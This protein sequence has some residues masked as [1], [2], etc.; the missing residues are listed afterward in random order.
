MYHSIPWI[1]SSDAHQL[2]DIGRKTTGLYMNHA[3]FEEF[4]LVL[5]GAGGRKVIR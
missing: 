1:T 2:E 3:T 4:S 5:A